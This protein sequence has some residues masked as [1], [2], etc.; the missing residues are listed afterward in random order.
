MRQID[1]QFSTHCP[2]PGT[3]GPDHFKVQGVIRILPIVN[4]REFVD[5]IMV[6]EFWT[7]LNSRVLD[8]FSKTLLSDL[9]GSDQSQCTVPLPPRINF[10]L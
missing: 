5:I 7:Y 9:P 10:P 4:P 8:T 3:G 1:C 2:E 6:I